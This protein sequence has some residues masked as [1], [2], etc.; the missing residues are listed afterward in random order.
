MAEEAIKVKT[1]ATNEKAE[2]MKRKAP[3]LV[4]SKRSDEVPLISAT[5]G[6]KTGIYFLSLVSVARPRNGSGVGNGD[7]GS[8]VFSSAV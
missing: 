6:T 1:E 4:R 7:I 5:V 3:L 2:T 8:V